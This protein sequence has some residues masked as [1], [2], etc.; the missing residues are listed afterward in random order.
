MEIEVA[1]HVGVTL[2]HHSASS[3]AHEAF[4]REGYAIA[5]FMRE[6]A[7]PNPAAGVCVVY[8]EKSSAA[9]KSRIEVLYPMP[10]TS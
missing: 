10:R 4:L 7:I 6:Q 3:V 5:A 8:Y 1:S 2:T 9:G